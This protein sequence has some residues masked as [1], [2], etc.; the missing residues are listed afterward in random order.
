MFRRLA[1]GENTGMITVLSFFLVTVSA[2]IH[3]LWNMLLKNSK[4]KIIFYLNIHLVYTLLF[5]F[6]LL[7]YDVRGISAYGW[8]LVGLSALT[9]FFYQ[10]FLCRAYENGDMSLTYP[11]IRSSPL[12]VLILGFIFLGEIPSWGALLGIGIVV[13][14]IYV[15]NQEDLSF[16]DVFG[17]LKK[18]DK[19][20]MTAAVLTAIFS[21]AYSAVDKKG[22]LLIEPVLFF[23]LFF[24]ISGFMFLVYLLF[25]KERRGLYFTVL[26][27]DV[28]KIILAAILEFASY[29]L[30]LFAFRVSK[31]AY[32]VALRQISV[33]FGA[34]YGIYF[35]KEKYGKVRVVG[36]VV[37]FLGIFLITVFG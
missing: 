5:S 12:F 36:S 35:L 34:A 16:K 26:R 4:D 3:P 19:K 27:G 21:G 31:V 18:L 29:I 1:G 37:I 32:V 2:V 6:I 28:V 8:V 23:Y 33:V 11:V 20:A 15:L 17:K 24:A 25:L 9:H 7:R 22:V 10:I 13:A 14:G 30:I